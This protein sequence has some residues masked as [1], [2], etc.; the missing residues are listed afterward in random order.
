MISCFAKIE[1][2]QC[3]KSESDHRA[4]HCS[5]VATKSVE[6]KE[7]MCMCT[8]LGFI[9]VLYHANNWLPHPFVT[10][11][12]G[13]PISMQLYTF[14]SCKRTPFTRKIVMLMSWLPLRNPLIISR[15]LSGKNITEANLTCSC[16]VIS[17]HGFS[18]DFWFVLSC[19]FYTCV[20]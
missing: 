7:L 8:K 13:Y 14:E 9:I 20:I 2:C 16:T 15:P 19:F 4:K 17:G 1:C 11:H 6:L 18:S 3:N 10:N 12:F 5:Y